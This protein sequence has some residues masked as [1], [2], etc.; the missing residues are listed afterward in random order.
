MAKITIVGDANDN[1]PT[2]TEDSLIDKRAKTAA[3]VLW[4]VKEE[5]KLWQPYRTPDLKA[6]VQEI[7]D[8][9]GWEGNALA[10]WFSGPGPSP[11]R[12]GK[13]PGVGIV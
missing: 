4:E 12:G 8:R 1:A 2:F 3:S 5:W 7:V 10:F 9:P 13:R 11:Q 6:V